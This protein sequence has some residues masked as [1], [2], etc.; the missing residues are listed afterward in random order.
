MRAKILVLMMLSLAL[1]ACATTANYEAILNTWIGA[2]IN[3]LVESW[4]YASNSFVAP[5]GNK[6]YVYE[7]GGSFTMPTTYQT[8]ARVYGYGNSA[9]GTATTNVYGGQTVTLWCRTFFEVNSS[10]IIINWR[11]EGNGCKSHYRPQEQRDQTETI[12]SEQ[13]E[14]LKEINKQNDTVSKVSE[15][16]EQKALSLFNKKY[17]GGDESD[18][19]IHKTHYNGK[20]NQCFMYVQRIRSASRDKEEILDVNEDTYYG[21]LRISKGNVVCVIKGKTCKREE[22]WNAYVRELMEE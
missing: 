14:L 1:S 8:T 12:Q 22:E 16:D 10:D 6:V 15:C 21:T 2:D 9:Y 13:T 5:N 4:G 11:W 17:S 3:K 19:Y 18:K 20:L 7:R